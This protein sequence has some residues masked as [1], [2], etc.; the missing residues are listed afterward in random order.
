MSSTL[1]TQLADQIEQA[2]VHLHT[3]KRTC[4]GISCL[5]IPTKESAEIMRLLEDV[6]NTTTWLAM[7]VKGAFARSLHKDRERREGASTWPQQ[8]V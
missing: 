3:V 2:L 8:E 6:S 1:G 4:Q 5:D 7:E